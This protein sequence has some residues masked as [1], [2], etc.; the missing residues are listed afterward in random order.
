MSECHPYLNY[1]QI[2]VWREQ[3]LVT[4]NPCNVYLL[5]LKRG[6]AAVWV[7]AAESENADLNILV[8]KM[9][10]ALK[11]PIVESMVVTSAEQVEVINAKACSHLLMGEIGQ[12]VDRLVQQVYKISAPSE[13]NSNK[14]LKAAAWHTM[15]CYRDGL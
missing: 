11:C 14:G 8:Q 12:L 7:S 2:P 1:M 6:V 10:Q 15:Q 13:L 3:Q 4:I 5:Q 9:L